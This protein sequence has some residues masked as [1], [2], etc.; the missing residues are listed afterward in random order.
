M[1]T[2][3]E[4]RLAIL[5]Q[6]TESKVLD[7]LRMHGWTAKIEREAEHGECLVIVAEQSG[8]SHRVAVMFSSATANAVY[9]ALATEVEHIFI[10][11]ELYKLNEYAYGITIPVDRV[12]NFHSLLV[13]WNK[14]ISTGKFAPNAASV[15]ITAY[16]PTHRT[17]LSEAP[18]EAI[19]LRLRQFTSVSLARK[20]VQARATREGVVLDDEVVRTKAEGLA[21]SLRNAGDYFRMLDGQNVS[22][23]VLSLYYGSMS[24]AFAEMLA[25]PNGPA[26]LAVIEDGTK[27]GHGLCTLDGERDGLEHIVVS[28]IATGFFASWMK[29]LNIPI[30]EFPRQKPKVYT[31]LDKQSKSSWLT[32]EG[33][34]ARIPEVSDL[35]QDIFASKPSWIT[36]TYDHAANPSS[37]LPEQDERVSTTYAIF[38]DDS[39]RLTVDDIAA[40]PG[41]I[42]QITEIASKDPGRHFRVAVDTTGKDLWWDALRIH[43]SPFERTALIVPAFGAVGDYRAICVALLYSLSIMV[44]Y[45]PSV[46][47]RVQ[48]GDLDHLRVL[49][50][51]YLA[52]VE[53]VLP[54]QFLE[55][56]TAQRVFAQQPGAFW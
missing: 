37:S 39:A 7:P 40:F 53:R 2:G 9:K 5:R 29:F 38:V 6:H 25:A 43:R 42:S 22:Q 18:I 45:R 51:A 4:T 20:L 54:E 12:D 27:Q 21:F 50:E 24:F 46:W 13:S 30:G 19:W 35:F 56:I 31:D 34:F 33:L 16:P 36:P 47:R 41:P 8:H 23:R 17:L 26:A 44:R 32:I 52:V 14:A 10:D 11:G 1:S 48:E 49:I 3:W 55:C 15:S 28:P